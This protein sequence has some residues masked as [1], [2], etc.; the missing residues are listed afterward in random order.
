MMSKV[1]KN[2]PAFF[3]WFAWLIITA[4]L[5]I[6]HDHHSG[7]SFIAKEDACPGSNGK[8]G[9]SSGFPMHC[10]AFNDLTS[11]KATIF[12]IIENIQDNVIAFSSFPDP[13]AFE[14]Q[15]RGISIFDIR[16]PI[17]NAYYLELTPLR[18]PPSI[19]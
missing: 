1:I 19:S 4:H 10:H 17:L 11:E 18:A 3:L 12:F 15:S 9:H 7:D 8:T 13:F 2:I 6:P 5:M 16:K 14:I